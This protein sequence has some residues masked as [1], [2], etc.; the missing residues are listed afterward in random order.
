MR[1]DPARLREALAEVPA[2]VWSLPS[3]YSVTRVHHGYSTAKVCGSRTEPAGPFGWVVD[4]FAPV[5]AAW[6]ARLEPGGFIAPHRDRGPWFE[7]WHVPIWTAGE[8]G[9]G[10]V[11]EPG[12]AFQ[13][14]HWEPHSVWNPTDRPRTHLIIDR[15]VQVD[16]PPAGLETY[17]IPDRYAELVARAEGA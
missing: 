6:L 11:P 1:F 17:P 2:D 16:R 14:R 9:D 13:V 8:W 12:V 3:A 5:A 10:H 15:D 4:E 7:R